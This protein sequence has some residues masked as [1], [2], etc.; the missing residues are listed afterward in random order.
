MKFTTSVYTEPNNDFLEKIQLHLNENMFDSHKNYLEILK[1]H[2][3]KIDFM[4]I[5]KYPM[6]GSDL[7]KSAISKVYH[8]EKKEL[9]I[10]NG[11][12]NIL[13]KIF[14][15]LS[16][17][18]GDFLIP[19]PSWSFYNKT[20]DFLNVKY[21]E[22]N[23]EE[24]N[25]K[26]SYRRENIEEKIN[27]DTSVILFCSPNNP[28]GNSIDYEDICYFLETYPDI[29]FI[30][31][32][33]YIGFIEQNDLEKTINLIKK[34]HNFYIVRTFSK[35]YGLANLRL[36]YAISIANNIKYLENLS[37]VFG[38]PTFS[39]KILSD[40]ISNK[41]LDKSL[42]NEFQKVRAYMLHQNCYFKDFT[43]LD[44]NSNFM[45][46]EIKQH[47]I[48]TQDLYNFFYQ[49]NFII[50]LESIFNKNYL[51]VTLASFEIMN[52]FINLLKEF[53]GKQQYEL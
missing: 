29:H 50:K 52:K 23:L 21:I 19:S 2:F 18:K 17:K 49:N 41:E 26:F 27:K 7:A 15:M 40:R 9:F 30:L 11:S 38:I 43:F 24:K 48:S 44:T 14:L 53:D 39:Q 5:N 10:D 36:G 25:S 1:D 13:R 16:H 31:D 46:I 22:Y 37:T 45:L 8:L 35:F 12:S 32:Q 6:L 51:R 34:Y 4:S 3:S 42:Q 20:L 47:V 28:T 33:A